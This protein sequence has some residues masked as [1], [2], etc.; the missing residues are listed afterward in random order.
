MPS[1]GHSFSSICEEAGLKTSTHFVNSTIGPSA[2]QC[3][4][5]RQLRITAFFILAVVRQFL[6]D[7]LKSKRLD[8]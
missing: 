5:L 3:I 8:I 6:F 4:A 7:S 1:K 2:R